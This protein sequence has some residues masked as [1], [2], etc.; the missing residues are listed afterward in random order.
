MNK[1]K[2][3]IKRIYKT[4]ININDNICFAKIFIC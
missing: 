2:Y 1:I 4:Y 3:K